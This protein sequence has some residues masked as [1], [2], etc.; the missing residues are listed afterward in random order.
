LLLLLV[1]Q[2][3]LLVELV[4]QKLGVEWGGEHVLPLLLE[5]L[6]LL[7]LLLVLDHLHLLLHMLLLDHH[8][9][10]VQ[11][12]S[13]GL[14]IP[15]CCPLFAIFV[16]VFLLHYEGKLVVYIQNVYFRPFLSA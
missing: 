1:D 5:G 2:E 6:L 9:I 16:E 13:W 4:H 12:L 7:L 15:S 3:L 14:F 10:R 8:V 11:H